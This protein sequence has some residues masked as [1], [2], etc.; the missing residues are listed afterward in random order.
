MRASWPNEHHNNEPHGCYAAPATDGAATTNAAIR[1]ARP[2]PIHT[3]DAFGLKKNTTTSCT[4]TSNHEPSMTER[5]K[6]INLRNP[7]ENAAPRM[8]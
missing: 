2:F 5:A 4:C 3:P 7:A 8:A 1:Q 6:P